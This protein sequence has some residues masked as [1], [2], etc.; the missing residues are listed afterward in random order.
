MSFQTELKHRMRVVVIT[1]VVHAIFIIIFYKLSYFLQCI[2][3]IN[4][5]NYELINVC[6]EERLHVRHS[7]IYS[8]E[9]NGGFTNA[10]LC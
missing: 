5:Q 2:L 3:C 1:L 7:H 4:V 9:L 8:Q 10:V 6:E